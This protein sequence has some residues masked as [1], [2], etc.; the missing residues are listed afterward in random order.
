MKMRG[1][2][3]QKIKDIHK[4]RILT[5]FLG[6]LEIKCLQKD[7]FDTWYNESTIGYGC[8]LT[9]AKDYVERLYHYELSHGQLSNSHSDEPTRD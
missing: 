3:H 8:S 4:V 7:D 5:R 9:E 1:N 6:Q 2:F